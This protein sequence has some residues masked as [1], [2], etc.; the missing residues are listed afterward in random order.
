[1]QYLVAIHKLKKTGFQPKRTILLTYVPDEEIGGNEGMKVLL[2]S[3]YFTDIHSHG[4]AVALD[5]GL[6]SEDESY[7]LFYGERLPWWVSVTALGNTGIR[8]PLAHVRGAK[9]VYDGIY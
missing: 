9:V 5:E 3:K 7:A 6:A 2:E 1:M 8:H 4:I